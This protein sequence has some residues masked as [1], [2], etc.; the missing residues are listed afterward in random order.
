[1]FFEET[2]NEFHFFKKVI[3]ERYELRGLHD[4]DM[5]IAMSHFELTTIHNG[6]SGSWLKHKNVSS[7]DDMQYAMTWRCK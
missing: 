6:L 7:I 5:G 2:E 4:I 1:V 3:S